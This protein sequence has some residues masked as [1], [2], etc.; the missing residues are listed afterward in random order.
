M[1]ESIPQYLRSSEWSLVL[2]SRA[3]VAR[4]RAKI[5]R[6][7]RA[8]PACED[9]R[10]TSTRNTGDRKSAQQSVYMMSHPTVVDRKQAFLRQ[11]KQILARGIAPSH[12]L[13]DVAEEGGIK[14]K[15]L[16]DVMMKSEFVFTL[17][18]FL[19]LMPEVALPARMGLF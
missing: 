7:V 1:I 2:E 15:V 13:F 16:G 9:I 10:T 11:Q 19:G 6:R 3:R 12:R 8:T 18:S 17:G 14:K 5:L 4:F